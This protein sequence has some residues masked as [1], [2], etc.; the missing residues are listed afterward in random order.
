MEVRRFEMIGKLKEISKQVISDFDR[1]DKESK[2]IADKYGFKLVAT[3]HAD[4]MS[5]KSFAGFAEPIKD[6][7]CNLFRKPNRD[8]IYFPY[9]KNKQIWEDMKN[10]KNWSMQIVWDYIGSAPCPFSGM[11]GFYEDKKLNN[12]MLFYSHNQNFKGHK[13]LKEIKKSEYYKMIGE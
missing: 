8:G 5:G 1:F 4:F 2:D 9:A 10:V 11:M 13:D 3:Q 12:K 7:D 6:I